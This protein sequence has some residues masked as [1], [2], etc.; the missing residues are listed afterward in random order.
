MASTIV[1]APELTSPGNLDLAALWDT[2][3]QNCARQRLAPQLPL[4]LP[5]ASEPPLSSLQAQFLEYLRTLTSEPDAIDEVAFCDACHS[6]AWDDDLCSARDGDMSICDACWRSWTGCANC[7]DRYPDADMYGTLDGSLIC[8]RCRDNY[9]NYC[10]ECDGH[11]HADDDG[12][13]HDHACDC[14]SPQLS[15]AIRNDGVGPLANDT[16]VTVLLPAGIISAEGLQAITNCLYRAGN[17]GP[18]SAGLRQLAYELEPLGDRWQTSTGNYPK[19][20]SRHAYSTRKI[21]ITPDIMAQVGCIA[22]DHSQPVSVAIEVT[23]ELNLGSAD[24]GNEGSC[25]WGE[26]G[27]SRCALKTNGGFGLRSFGK[28]TSI[29]G[30]GVSGRA[31]VMPLRLNEKEIEE[32]GKWRELVPTFDTLTPDAFAVFNG[33]G[34]LSNYTAPRIMAHLAGWTYRKISFSCSPMWVNSGG[35]LVAPED[36]VRQQGDSLRLSVSE[37]ADLYHT[38]RAA[39][40]A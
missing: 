36:T 14:D 29:W 27:S 21:K 2:Y 31:W 28:T 12:H 23:R 8:D 25:W 5:A 37:H 16:R 9:Y 20:L 1:P 40:P 22:R 11:Y 32:Q 33:Y 19:R 6:P 24:F 7:E 15:F 18:G 13:D 34:D 26:Y 4:G 30:N 10:E 35:Y 38:E 3:W 17:A 39:I